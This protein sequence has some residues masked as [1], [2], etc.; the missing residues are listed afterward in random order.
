MRTVCSVIFLLFCSSNRSYV[1][2][3]GLFGLMVSEG[4]PFVMVVVVVAARACSRGSY[5]M[6]D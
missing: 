5:I 2:K 6:A 1:R 4:P 3:K